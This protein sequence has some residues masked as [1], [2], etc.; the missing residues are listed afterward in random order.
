MI[1]PSDAE[2]AAMRKCLKSFGS[3]ASRIGIQRPVATF[4]ETEALL[5]VEAIVATFTEAMI[6]HQEA[7]RFPPA[8]ESPSAIGSKRAMSGEFQDDPLPESFVGGK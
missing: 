1:D 3:V 4:S 8:P 2:R 6:D 5:V 7:S